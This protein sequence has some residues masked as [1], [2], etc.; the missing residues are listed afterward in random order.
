LRRYSRTGVPRERHGAAVLAEVCRKHSVKLLHFSTDYVFDGAKASGYTEEDQPNPLSVYGK[1]KLL[2][3]QMILQ[4]LPGSLIIRTEWIYGDGGENFITKVRKVASEKGR[5]EVVDD[6]RGSPTY[7][8][9]WQNQLKP[10]SRAQGQAS[11]TSQTAVRAHVRI[12]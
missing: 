5:V 2:G 9:T 7:A 3:E 12:C 4:L 8:L 10:S 11:I 6:Q 1:S